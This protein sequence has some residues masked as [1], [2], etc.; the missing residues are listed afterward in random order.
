MDTTSG[1]TLEQK[2]NN[3]PPPPPPDPHSFMYVVCSLQKLYLL[4]YLHGEEFVEVRL[5]LGVKTGIVQH[6]DQWTEFIENDDLKRKK[7]KKLVNCK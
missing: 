4:F 1:L 5:Q 7:K 3:P 2:D 6:L